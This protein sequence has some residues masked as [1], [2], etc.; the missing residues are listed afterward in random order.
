LKWRRR[1]WSLRHEGC[2]RLP[3]PHIRYLICSNSVVVSAQRSDRNSNM[4][5]PALERSSQQ[6]QSCSC[7]GGDAKSGRGRL[8]WWRI[9]GME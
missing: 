3:L 4:Q 6:C 5:R 2:C 7:G 8:N 1:W 9:I